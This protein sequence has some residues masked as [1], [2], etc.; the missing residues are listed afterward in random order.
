MSDDEFKN[1]D[2]HVSY[3]ANYVRTKI[4]NNYKRIEKL[5]QD[6]ARLR[7][8]LSQLRSDLETSLDKMR[9]WAKDVKKQINPAASQ[10]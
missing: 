5:E 10:G 1:F 2:E 8:E 9:E 3:S 7:S 6:N 4:A